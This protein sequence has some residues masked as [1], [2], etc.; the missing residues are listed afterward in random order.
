MVDYY[1][2]LIERR[3]DLLREVQQLREFRSKDGDA[4]ARANTQKRRTI[5][6]IN[7]L[8]HALDLPV[9]DDDPV[10]A[11][12]DRALNAGQVPDFKARR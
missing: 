8:G 4:V 10:A 12:W 9:Y 6:Q 1:A 3:E 2:D 7:A 11:A 5:E